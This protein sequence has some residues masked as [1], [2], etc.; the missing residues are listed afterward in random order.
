M[1]GNGFGT[2]HTHPRR[3]VVIGGLLGLIDGSRVSAEETCQ[4]PATMMCLNG[5][6]VAIAEDTCEAFGCASGM[7]CR[8]GR[9]V[10]SRRRRRRG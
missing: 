9:C 1:K 10:A 4:C 3:G 5:G 2:M 6:C 7:R 8:K